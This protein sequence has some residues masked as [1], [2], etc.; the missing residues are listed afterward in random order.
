MRISGLDG[1]LWTAG[2]AGHIAL[3]AIIFAK[4]RFSSYPVFSALI[5][6]S[7]LRTVVLFCLRGHY[8]D[9]LYN[10]TYWRFALVDAGLQLALIFEIASKVFRPRGTWA[11]DVRSKLIVSMLGSIV[12]AGILAYLQD[13]T[14][15][16]LVENF[17]IK[18]GF[19]SVVL[20]AALF[21]LMIVLSSEAGLNWRSHIASIATGMAVYCFVGILIELVSRFSEANTLRDLLISLQVIR[22]WLYVGCV[23]YWGY[24]LWLPEPSPRKM[25]PRMEGQ[26]A[27]LRQAVI[28]R[29]S[30]WTK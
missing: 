22:R 12:V 20:N 9:P 19:F 21:T 28:R 14:R 3:L 16:D 5:G 11:V 25:S 23:S 10:H 2:L 18:I 29:N 7:V 24:S 13:S 4:K 17:A 1:F 6:F 8:G 15:H 27:A 26:V 30:E